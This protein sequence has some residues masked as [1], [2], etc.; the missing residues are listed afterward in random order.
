VAST[1]TSKKDYQI[2]DDLLDLLCDLYLQA[3][4]FYITHQRELLAEDP[5]QIK[6]NL[7]RANGMGE[8]LLQILKHL[9]KERINGRDIRRI[10]WQ[11]LNGTFGSG[12]GSRGAGQE[13]RRNRGSKTT[14]KTTFF[15][16]RNEQSDD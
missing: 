6:H 10:V 13:T 14:G 12:T 11:S 7:A 2:S 15:S 4:G 16:Q 5:N 1:G 3:T 8:L 9:D